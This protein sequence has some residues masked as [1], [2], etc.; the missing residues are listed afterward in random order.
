MRE[1]GVVVAV[2][3]VLGCAREREAASGPAARD[4]A[5][6]TIVENRDPAWAAGEGFTVAERPELDAGKGDDPE[7]TLVLPAAAI[8]L[9]DGGIAVLDA[10]VSRIKRYGKDG[11][12][13]GNVGR[14]GSGPGEH[15]APIWISRWPGDS[16]ATYDILGRRFQVFG[17]DAKYARAETP[18]FTFGPGRPLPPQPLGVFADGTVLARQATRPEFPFD[19]P[20]GSIRQDSARLIRLTLAGAER[21]T[22]GVLP[23]G[24]TTGVRL[25]LGPQ[26]MLVP[27]NV[28]LTP[29]LSVALR[30]DTAW[31]GT[32]ERWEIANYAPD[33]RLFRLVRL[34]RPPQE[35]TPA[36]LDSAREAAAGALAAFRGLPPGMDTVLSKAIRSGPAPELLPAHGRVLVDDSGWLWVE[37]RPTAISG[38]PSTGGGT[39]LVFSPE[40]TYQ[41]DVRMPPS[42][43]PLQIGSD[44]VLGLWE[45][46]DG[47][48][49]VRVHTIQK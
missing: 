34:D 45:D 39:W 37:E 9:A 36:I 13:A 47:V 29:S 40:G 28:L 46:E 38:G 8:R 49:H 16:F 14:Q 11:G 20:E 10:G 27:V 2:V 44:W 26:S 3:L 30:N 18:N 5:G 31:V 22:F 33:G 7:A 35:V 43:A 12:Y 4:S 6:I 15:Q 1:F 42:F 32:G 17:P 48:R 19:G 24:Q 21:D 25:S 23:A 41:G